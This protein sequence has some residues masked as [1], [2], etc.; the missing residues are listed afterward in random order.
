MI[1]LLVAAGVGFL[2]G[3]MFCWVPG[4]GGGRSMVVSATVLVP[5]TDSRPARPGRRCVA[6]ARR[7]CG[8]PAV[9]ELN[10]RERR[11]SGTHDAWWAYC[12]EHAYGRVLLDD[13]V[14]YAYDPDEAVLVALFGEEVGDG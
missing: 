4:D 11:S 2:S 6:G 8:Q 1:P 3:L 9:L 10:R 12:E 13:G 14:H 7:R 5:E